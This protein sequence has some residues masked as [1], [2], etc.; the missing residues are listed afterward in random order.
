MTGPLQ[1]VLL[2]SCPNAGGGLL[3]LD[4]AN[5]ERLSTVQ[6]TGIC[7]VPGGFL[8]ARQSGDSNV[9]RRA[10]DGGLASTL[11]AENVLDLHD[12]A[13][14]GGQTYV[15]ATER[16]AVLQL[17]AGMRET[18]RWALRGERDSAHLNSI[19]FHDGRLLAS[20]FGQ[21]DT[22][23]GYKGATA[24]A[25]EV[26]DVETGEVLITGLSQPHSLASH[27][28][29]LWLCDS[30]ARRVVSWRG[31]DEP[32]RT[33]A[34]DGYARGLAFG[35]KHIYVGLSRSRNAPAPALARAR[36]VVLDRTTLAVLGAIELPADEVYD[37]AIVEGDANALR[38]SALAEANAELAAMEQQRD[39]IDAAV[40]ERD[41]R[42]SAM[43]GQLAAASAAHAAAQAHVVELLHRQEEREFRLEGLEAEALA[44]AHWGDLLEAD[45][46]RLRSGV[47]ALEGALGAQSR[48]LRAWQ[49]ALDGMRASRSWRVTRPLRWLATMLGRPGEGVD[50]PPEVGMPAPVDRT[51][52]TRAGLPIHGLQFEDHDAPVVSIVVT[53]HGGFAMTLA[54]LRSIRRYAGDIAV[55]VVLI[56]DA[57][58]EAEM[59]RFR[60]VPGLRYVENASNLGFLRSANQA[61]SLARGD[62]I[63]FLNNDTVVGAGWL[64]ALLQTFARFHD[65]GLAG[66]QLVYPDGRLQ[67][68]G[69][70][71][72]ND[73]RALNY[74]RDGDPA[75]PDHAFVREVDYVSGASML[76]RSDLFRHL[77]G[78]DERYVPAYYED[79]DL[80]FRVRE[81]AGRKVYYQ[82]ASVVRHVEGASHG[83]DIDADDGKGSQQVNRA[84]FAARWR[85]VLERGQLPA[86]AHLFL[87]RERAQLKP[88][89]LV[90]DRMP[91]RTDRDAGSRAIWQLMR[92]LGLHGMLVKFWAEEVDEAGVYAA[93]LAAH[94]I[95]LASD[96]GGDFDAWMAA[97]GAYLDLV[98]LSRP[99]VAER[100]VDA[101]R[102]HSTAKL[103]FYGH[104]I[105][106]LRYI[107][108]MRVDPDPDLAGFA[109]HAREIEESLWRRADLVAYPS[110]AES[111]H[112]GQWMREHDAPGQAVAVPLFAYEGLPEQ[113]GEGL[114]ERRNILFV[115]G[116]AHA[117]NEDGVLW[118]VRYV[119][120]AIHRQHPD[121]RLCLVGADPPDTVVALSR[122]DV[123]VTG[124]IPEH[125]LANY[126]RSARL[127]VAPLRFGA[128]VKGKV[129]EAMRHGVPCVTT[130]AG[131]QGLEAADCLRVADDP[132]TFAAMVDALVVDDAAWTAAARGGI[133][134][135]ARHFSV[136]TVWRALSPVVDGAGHADV[137]ARLAAI[138]AARSR[139]DAGTVG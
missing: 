44:Q 81:E 10:V 131:A 5:V 36:I 19:C 46:A 95:E 52:P 134:F 32:L 67:E 66:S 96:G 139:S 1:D 7:A 12:V 91:P 58:G 116:F 128:G 24:G 26:F 120:P 64:A 80:A 27:D 108:Q 87:A 104:D 42:L 57:S 113:V 31:P 130:S 129:L 76:V 65:C 106:H 90:V 88:V 77:G 15:V 83:T 136:E 30:E 86:G 21:F 89:V 11:L 111:R 69:G 2:V 6:T 118:F 13:W 75:H 45:S 132:A 117:P 33:L 4:G 74:G 125:E 35:R 17:D 126:Y 84:V 3:L 85:D 41:A 100:H 28:D 53:A 79:T 51:E 29:A 122:S 38:R 9:L 50:P 68:A 101:V 39:A 121:Y 56:E 124:H 22:H 54:C 135:L 25:G 92:V 127:V 112:A 107:S 62:Y 119:W 78:F 115:G 20:R 99:L 59:A 137:A 98:V 14:H 23:R 34:L 16:N 72:W 43:A 103:L 55:E 71:V 73:G 94:G 133:E 102:R 105:H 60:G 97:N 47:D 37:I 123:L 18:R 114:S 40:S 70:V 109:H 63:H 138:E 8:W 49:H 82:P 48:L 93:N 61:L 110:E